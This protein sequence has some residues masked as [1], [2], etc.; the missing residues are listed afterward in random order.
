[1]NLVYNSAQIWAWI[2]F[3]GYLVGLILLGY[4]VYHSRKKFRSRKKQLD[5]SHWNTLKIVI[6]LTFASIVISFILHFNAALLYIL[7]ISGIKSVN[8]CPIFETNI[9]LFFVSKYLLYA[10]FSY[11]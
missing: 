10:L 11:R 8:M 3:F 2:D 9:L 5:L 4:A 1:M 7:L 6:V